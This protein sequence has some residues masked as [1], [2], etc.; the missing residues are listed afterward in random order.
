MPDLTVEQKLARLNAWLDFMKFFLGSVVV[1]L[2]SII[3]GQVIKSRE[4]AIKESEEIGKY[5]PQALEADGRKR[6]QFA[7]FFAHVTR[8]PRY[9]AQW[10]G[11]RD[12]I[13]K[14]IEKDA[15]AA[16]Q[17]RKLVADLQAGTLTPE[18]TAKVTEELRSSKPSEKPAKLS[19]RP[20]LPH[21]WQRSFRRRPEP[22]RRSSRSNSPKSI[23]MH[24]LGRALMSCLAK[25]LGPIEPSSMRR[26]TARSNPA[27]FTCTPP[28]DSW[29]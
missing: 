21:L 23:R 17:Q 27:D 7:D 13:G 12:D 6:Y 24:P 4:V 19:W 8:D 28:N 2:V 1:A 14:E 16:E 9:R 3:L 25:P 5:I 22:P 20:S 10:I 15:K 26:S 18:K 29:T 11:Y